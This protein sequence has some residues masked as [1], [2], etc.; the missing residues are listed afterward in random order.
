MANIDEREYSRLE[1]TFINIV[2]HSAGE[3]RGDVCTI[4]NRSN[5]HMRTFKQFWRADRGIM[6]RICTHNVG[7]P[8]PDEYRILNGQDNGMHGCDGCCIP[9]ATEEEVN[10]D[11]NND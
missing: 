6:E 2:T 5:H 10:A 3:C 4:H 8:D 11:G 9:F 1:N 7:H